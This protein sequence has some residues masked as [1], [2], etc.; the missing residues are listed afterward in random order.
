MAETLGSGIG[1]ALWVGRA[2]QMG[3][4]IADELEQTVQVLPLS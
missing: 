3:G 2:G 4:Y 1:N